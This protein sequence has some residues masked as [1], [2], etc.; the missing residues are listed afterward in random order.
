M[1]SK[2]LL[3]TFILSFSL[4]RLDAQS[5]TINRSL[6]W[7]A[8]Q[9]ISISKF[10]KLKLPHF[11]G[12]V[13]L[14]EPAKTPWFTESIPL[15][16]SGESPSYTFGRSQ[17]EPISSAE[18]ELLKGVTIP[19]SPSVNIH[20][21][22]ERK[23]PIL[24]LQLLPL[25][26]NNGVIE[27]LSS[28]ELQVNIQPLSNAALRT[29]RSATTTESVLSSG[30]FVKVGITSSGVY[31]I[32][33]AMLAAM[34]MNVSINPKNL[35]VYGNGGAMLPERNNIYYPDDLIEN[36]IVVSGESDN[37][38]DEGDYILFYAQG[39]TVWT[40]DSNR[41]LFRQQRN[42]YADTTWYFIT[43]DQGPGK[44]ISPQAQADAPVTAT[45][46]TFDDYAFIE[47]DEE[48]F[49][50]SGRRWFGNRMEVITSH[51]F[52]VGMT[53]LSSGPHK[54][55]SRLANRGSNASSFSVSVNGQTFNQPVNASD[56]NYLS[57]YVTENESVFTFNGSNPVINISVSKPSNNSIGW[58][59][60][61]TLNVKRNLVMDG[62]WM[63]FRNR[64]LTGGGE[65]VEFVM[66]NANSSVRIW[67]VT[68]L[69]DIR[70]Q[71][72]DINGSSL[73]FK[74]N[75]DSLREF[76]AV[77]VN[78][79][80]AQ[81]IPG[82]PVANQNLHGLAQPDMIIVTPR[83]LINQANTLANL[84][85]NF[86]GLDVIVAEV[87]QIYNEFSSGKQDIAGIRNFVRMFY[88]R[89][90]N[91]PELMPQYLLMMGDGTFRPKRIGEN[92]WTQL[93]T[94]ESV[95]S[96]N[97]IGS[98]GSD[99]FFGLLDPT[100]GASIHSSGAG[101]LD[102]SIGRLP[103]SN[104]DEANAM[105][106]K[107]EYY[108][109]SQSTM[110]DW[111]NRVCFVADDEDSNTHLEQ[112]E[113]VSN[114]VAQKHPVYNID[115]IYLDAYP[116]ES[117][118]GG[119]RY[120]LV[121]LEIDNEMERGVLMMNY[122]GHGGEEGLALERVITIPDI[123]GYS[124]LQNMPLFLTA[125]CEFSRFDNPDFTSA[126][127][128]L[129][130]NPQGGAV[131]AFTTTRLTFS[132]SNQALNRNVMD[133]LFSKVNG[134]YQRMGDILRAGKNKTGS[135]A[136]NRSFALMGDPALMLAY[137]RQQV[138]TSTVNGK[139][140]GAFPDTIS[141]LELV[142]ITGFVSADGVNPD[143]TFNGIVIP[144]VFDKPTTLYTLSND[145]GA[146]GSVA[147]PFQLQ[148]NV[149]FR[150]PA[151]V[152]N[153]LFSFSFVVPQ[154]IQLQYGF[155]KISYYARKTGTLTDA[156][157]YLNNII[158]GGFS[159]NPTTDDQGPTVQLYMNN[160][161]FVSGGITD[162]NP[163]LLAYVEDDIG[164]NTVGTGIGHDI[165][166]VL[167][168][169]SG[170][171]YILNDF[172]EPELDNFRKGKVRY[173][174]RNLAVGPHSLT[175][176]VWDVANNSSTAS[177]DFVVVESEEM[178]INHVLNYPN[179]FTTNTQFFFESNQPGVPLVV[180]I[181][182]FTV[183]GKLVKN[184]ETVV[185]TSGYRSEP[186]AWNGRDDY[187]DK[188]GRGVYIYRLKVTSPEGK[189]AEKFEKLVILN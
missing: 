105:L 179:P 54:I 1:K 154:D 158:V 137:P 135:S 52:S 38:F 28:F 115:K 66:G 126:G 151:S 30:N 45:A 100:E 64:E 5:L 188:I 146:G 110:N 14:E 116:Q 166:A 16:A 123:E 89:A 160:E 132:T 101:A 163:D 129:V 184:I 12:A 55:A 34:G 112:Q 19:S 20:I 176:K 125:T 11:Q 187:G 83:A 185:Q 4:L 177:I 73:R 63:D 141:A 103:V 74:V 87:S 107:I 150:G 172:Y 36:A 178:A 60:Y 23:K 144:T 152:V 153:G 161:K 86:D 169:N 109:T 189:T 131:A 111:R 143:P 99:D 18:A 102:I 156:H 142:T 51:S 49:L 88:E 21:V 72:A 37:T 165:T 25:R 76:V 95:E 58:I 133:T 3:L 35:R 164:I 159:T 121:N 122:A 147:V 39:P 29:S 170:S 42:L 108:M 130:I 139:N 71:N 92:G 171:P 61:L 81:P 162:E 56:L 104:P 10:S 124:N 43:A 168:G 117:G 90:G 79:S 33:R 127:E 27:K 65:V 40:Y 41:E 9:E 175:F 67:E 119:Q 32:P 94:Y 44:R 8:P 53:N 47:N 69:Y 57:P 48:N 149:I 140:P 120:P 91:D 186:I 180:E 145:I 6:R 24:E 148:Q 173:P 46:T 84:H 13:Y 82:G 50:H 114:V 59:D 62:S 182:V 93:P 113:L 136:N 98:Y 118:A 181:Q 157:G 97:P 174:F 138:F 77:N 167:D 128:Y 26:S 7:T 134:S 183:S 70:E 2:F 17:W 22:Y 96:V 155:G 75:A 78:G 31:Q 15:T 68:N 85:R 106:Y 80:F